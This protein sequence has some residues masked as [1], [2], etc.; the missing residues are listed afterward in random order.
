MRS[1][2]AGAIIALFLVGC[3]SQ[4]PVYTHAKPTKSKS[5][6]MYSK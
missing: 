4:G 3:T 2:I 6:H 1:I 5:V